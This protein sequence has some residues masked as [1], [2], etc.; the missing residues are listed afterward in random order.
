MGDFVARDLVDEYVLY[1]SPDILG[2][3]SLG[4]FSISGITD[5]KDRISLEMMDIDR[6]G[7]DVRIRLRP[8][9]RA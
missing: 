3:D 5:L 6:F 1:L 9:G 4:M 7:R 8:E 2:S